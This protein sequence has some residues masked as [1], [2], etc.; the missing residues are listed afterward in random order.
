MRRRRRQPRR[1]PPAVARSGEPRLRRSRTSCGCRDAARSIRS[2]PGRSQRQTRCTSST[3]TSS[4][5]PCARPRRRARAAATGFDTAIP[6]TCASRGA[7]AGS[8]SA[9]CTS[10]GTSSTTSSAASSATT[11]ASGQHEAFADW[12]RPR[13]GCHR[14]CR[15]A[16]AASRRRYFNSSKEMWARSYAQAVLTRSRGSAGSRRALADLIERGRRLRLAGC[17]VRAGGGRD[18]RDLRAARASSRPRVAVAA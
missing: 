3:P 2:S 10:S 6:S 16:S 5:C 13:P 14:G 7:T 1:Q 9:S 17:G 4:P 8:R 11:W 18:R 12:R 15:P